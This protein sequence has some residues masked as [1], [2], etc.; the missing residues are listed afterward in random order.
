MANNIMKSILI[1]TVMFISWS[2]LK[3]QQQFFVN[4]EKLDSA[5]INLLETAY[6]VKIKPGRYWYDPYSGA[7]G[8][9]GKATS[10]IMLANLNLGGKLK[11][12]ASNGNTGV[13]VNGRELPKDEFIVIQTLLNE[14]IA[15]GY[16]WLDAFG[17]TGM[18]GQHAT[19]NLYNLARQQQSSFYR[20]SYTGTG[21]G[22]SGRTFYI[23][24]EGFSYIQGN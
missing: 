24:G 23:I 9:E 21:S 16:Y 7:W 8:M 1:I 12:N 11:V 18:V 3:S 5:T 13:F 14:Y 6:Q 19:V 4:D 22:S 17:N 20:N 10:G 15:P 2:G